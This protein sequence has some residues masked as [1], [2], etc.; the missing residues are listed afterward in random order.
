M[1]GEVAREYLLYTLTNR[2]YAQFYCPGTAVPA[3]PVARRGHGRAGWFVAALAQAN[4]GVG[5]WE[6]GWTVEALDGP[7]VVVR[8]GDLRFLAR[9]DQCR[10]AGAA[11]ASDGSVSVRLPKDLLGFSPGFYMALGDLPLTAD[12]PLIRIYW[13]LLPRAAQP[14]VAAV[15]A[16]LNG[17]RLAFRAKVVDDPAEFTRCDAGVVY[18]ARSDFGVARPV[19][20]GIVAGLA[21]QLDPEVP[22][23]TKPLAP[24]IG[25]AEDPGPEHQSFG[26]HRCRLLAEGIVRAHDRGEP[27]LKVVAD[28]LAEHKVQIDRPYLRAGSDADPYEL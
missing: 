28:T 25:L 17:A 22:A 9:A 24:G 19:L 21:A 2:L 18:L 23:L 7:A 1:I 5:P 10:P 20:A 6:P 11:P 15:T 13:N 3:R 27:T 4:A 14:F 16:E 8:R 12:A 26:Q